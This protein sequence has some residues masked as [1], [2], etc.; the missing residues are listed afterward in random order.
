[1]GRVGLGLPRGR[2]TCCIWL[3]LKPRKR[4]NASRASLDLR[5]P[6]TRQGGSPQPTYQV[7]LK[8][9]CF[10]WD[11]N[12]L[13]ATGGAALSRGLRDPVDPMVPEESVVGRDVVWGLGKGPVGESQ[14]SPLGFG[15]GK[16]LPSSVDN[17]S[18]QETQLMAWDRALVQTESLTMCHQVTTRPELPVMNRMAS[19]SPS[20]NAG[21]ERETSQ[22][23]SAGEGVNK[24]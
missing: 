23:A 7:S 14:H 15:G 2:V 10:E 24:V 19:D 13:W 8:A 11:P 6:I 3:L 1:M 21:H 16:A 4:H 9:A 12:K 18:P 5:G 22:C 17:D 20:M